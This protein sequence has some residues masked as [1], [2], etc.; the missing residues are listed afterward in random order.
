MM[1]HGI[2]P[3]CDGT[4]VRSGAAVMWK[5]SA[6]G[7]NTIPLGG[8]VPSAVALDNYVCPDC[9]YVGSY[10]SDRPA[11][12]SIRAKWPRVSMFQAK[13]VDEG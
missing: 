7:G 10:I 13:V 2:C 9:G 3:K 4:G 6:F 8:F 11:L 12:A 1:R 5:R